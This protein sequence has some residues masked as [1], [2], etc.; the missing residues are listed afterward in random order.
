MRRPVLA[1][2]TAQGEFAMSR[3]SLRRCAAFGVGLAAL[4][5]SAAIAREV[6]TRA[7][8][9]TI[10]DNWNVTGSTARSPDGAVSAGISE[11][12]SGRVFVSFQRAFGMRVDPA[13]TPRLTILFA[14]TGSTMRYYAVA[15]PTSQRACVATVTSIGTGVPRQQARDVVT[16]L[17]AAVANFMTTI[18]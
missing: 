4:V 11:V 1:A 3:I 16:S 10:P 7:C 6:G 15:P 13:S 18:R 2:G 5:P 17:R 12:A 14:R 8:V 9:A